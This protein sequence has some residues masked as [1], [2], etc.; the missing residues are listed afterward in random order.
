[1]S[2]ES[3][4]GAIVVGPD[5]NGLSGALEAR[6]LRVTTV[7]S[8][9]TG[10]RLADAGL[11]DAALFVVTDTADAPAIGIAREA[12]AGVRIVAYTGDTLPEYARPTT[13][14]MVDPGLLDADAV[15]EELAADV[16]RVRTD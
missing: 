16:E 4:Q 7:A 14:L 15:A 5:A 2:N 6:G 1:M 11:A 9:V 13:D 3:G 10:D 12:N 8:G